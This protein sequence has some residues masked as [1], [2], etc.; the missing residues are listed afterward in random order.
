MSHNPASRESLV[1][2]LPCSFFENRY[3]V[4]KDAW[5]RAS[6]GHIPDSVPDD[7]LET[8]PRQSDL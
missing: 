7:E 1:R 8:G 6:S 2:I 5:R 3:P 4:G